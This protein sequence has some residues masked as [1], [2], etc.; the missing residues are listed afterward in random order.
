MTR[1]WPKMMKRG[2]AAAYCDLSPAKFMQEVA[3]GRIHQ[4]VPFGGEDHWCIDDL[5]EDVRQLTGRAYDWRKE[6]PGLAA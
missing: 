3:A 5:D 6:Q 4:P 2:T 1:P